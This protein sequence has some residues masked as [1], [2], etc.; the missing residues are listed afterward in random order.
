[1]VVSVAPKLWVEATQ[2]VRVLNRARRTHADSESKAMKA[3][4]EKGLSLDVVEGVCAAVDLGR[5][6]ELARDGFGSEQRLRDAYR[7]ASS[8]RD[9]LELESD[10]R[11]DRCLRWLGS[12]A[13]KAVRGVAELLG[14]PT[15][16]STTVFRFGSSERVRGKKAS[17]PKVQARATECRLALLVEN[18]LTAA[19]R[20]GIAVI[21]RRPTARRWVS[22]SLR[23]L[24]NGDL[25][26]VLRDVR[27][28]I[29]SGVEREVKAQSRRW[30]RL[31]RRS[32]SAARGLHRRGRT[33]WGALATVGDLVCTVLAGVVP[34]LHGYARL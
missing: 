23:D 2:L 25:A 16:S 24:E 3:L 28:K 5:E 9:R 1:M 6:L 26:Q 8:A 20:G 21:E 11:A 18:L 19:M 22:L 27:L 31:A 29:E 34:V 17:E 12:K 7:K 4:A 30:T 32:E 10:Q 13:K 33:W 14:F 15:P